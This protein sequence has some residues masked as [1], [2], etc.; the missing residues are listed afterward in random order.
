MLGYVLCIVLDFL[1]TLKMVSYSLLVVFILIPISS[2]SM[3][4]IKLIRI[5][6]SLFIL[7]IVV[8]VHLSPYNCFLFHLISGLK[9]IFIFDLMFHDFD[10]FRIIYSIILCF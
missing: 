8:L 4:F 2:M 3:V 7:I 10:G 6:F 5:L 9:T 1:L